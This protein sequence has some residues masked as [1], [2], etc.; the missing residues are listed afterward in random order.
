MNFRVFNMYH[1]K[2][3]KTFVHLLLTTK[4]ESNSGFKIQM[5][6]ESFLDSDSFEFNSRIHIQD[7]KFI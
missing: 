7:S 2:L 4:I 3:N 6:F 5:P 1:K